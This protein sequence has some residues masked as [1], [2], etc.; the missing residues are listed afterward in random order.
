[1]NEGVKGEPVGPTVFLSYARPDQERA[2]QLARAL[3]ARGFEVWWD[4]LIEGGAAFAES[5]ESA[6]DG[7]DAVVVA[8]SRAS[9]TSDWVRDEAAKGRDQR[10]FV[11]VSLDGVEP[12]LGFRQYQ[13]INLSR[14]QG[15][16]AAAEISSVARAIRVA[17]SPAVH[18]ARAGTTPRMGSV[19]ASRRGLLLAAAGVTVTGAAG[20]L[21]WRQGLLGGRASATGNSV[22][23][24]PFVNLSGDSSQDYFSDGLSEELRATLARNLSLRVM[25][26]ASS[27]KFRDRKDDATTIASKLGVAYL[28]DGSVRR[29]GNVL[30]ITSDLIEGATGFSRWSQTF[31]RVMQ[32]IFAIQSEI[33][34]TVADALVAR[35]GDTGDAVADGEPL[36]VASGSTR[37]VAAYDAYLRGRAQYDLS[38]DETSE[39]AALGQFDAAI[40]ADPGYAAAHA[41]RARSL[42]A[43]ANQYGEVAELP[44]LYDAAVASAHR[45]IELAPDHAE[46]YSTLGFTLFQGRLDAHGA[47]EPFERSRELGSGEATV[48]ARFAQYSAR[49]GRKTAAA[50]AIARALQLDPLN[51]LIHRAAGSIEYAARAFAESIPHARRALAMNPRM[52]RAHAAI[53]D[54]LLMLGRFE[55]ARVEFAAEPVE[56]FRLA[57]QAM[58]ERK[59]GNEAAARAARVKLVKDLGDRVLYQ[60][61][62]IHAQWGEL[63]A[64]FTKLEQARRIGDS[65]LIYLRNDPYLDPLRRD[66]RFGGLLASIGFD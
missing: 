39:R 7:S 58:V 2:E 50:D 31:D 33:A 5:I 4:A 17:A 1:V 45:A 57:G 29:S 26:Q 49:I 20:W 61:A 48:M 6:L 60:Q 34:D 8:W 47:R 32:D 65:G 66:P 30:R 42:T 23:V 52:S 11:P 38:A 64:A 53:G 54:A 62:Q 9:I 56:D 14:W 43:I 63:D 51:P 59:L 16:P 13:S 19:S 44:G 18:P 25:A 10:K 22:A 12:P 41:A 15:D 3:E 46:A 28:L 35:V 27:S 21:A 36:R 40:A 24:L 55:E 37:S